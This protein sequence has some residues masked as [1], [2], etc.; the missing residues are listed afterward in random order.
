MVLFLLSY[1]DCAI[2]TFLG[3][4]SVFTFGLPPNRPLAHAAASP[5]LV[6]SRIISRSNSANAPKIVFAHEIGSLP[7][8]W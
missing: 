7:H 4:L 6:L 2:A 5:A 3:V 8:F 1:N